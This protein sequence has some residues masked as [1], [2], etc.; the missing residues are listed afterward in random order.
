LA[1][2]GRVRGGGRIEI[3]GG[4]G[5]WGGMDWGWYLKEKGSCKTSDAPGGAKRSTAVWGI[6]L[7][8]GKA[9][10]GLIQKTLKY[11]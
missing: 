9:A 8:S 2:G 6:A 3:L 11:I 5:G 1:K 4:R 10:G 7:S